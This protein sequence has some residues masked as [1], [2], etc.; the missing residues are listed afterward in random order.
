MIIYLEVFDINSYQIVFQIQYTVLCQDRGEVMISVA[1]VGRGIEMR[2]PA[3][4]VVG[5][6]GRDP[7]GKEQDAPPTL[8]AMTAICSPQIPCPPFPSSRPEHFHSSS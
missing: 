2:W 3:G 6:W 4:L 7:S 8:I 5:T 1:R